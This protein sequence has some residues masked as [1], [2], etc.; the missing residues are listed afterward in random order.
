MGLETIEIV[1]TD[2]FRRRLLAERFQ[3][4]ALSITRGLHALMTILTICRDI[5]E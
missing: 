3:L 4:G 1:S 2:G 5:K